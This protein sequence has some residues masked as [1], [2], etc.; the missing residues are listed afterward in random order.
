MSLSHSEQYQT[1]QN[2]SGFAPLEAT[3]VLE[4]SGADR[5]KFLNSYL[6]Q[7][8]LSM[9]NRSHALGVFLTQKG[10]IVSD[11]RV[12]VL[13][14]KVLLL[15]AKDNGAKVQKH[16]ETFLMF[17]QAQLE[18]RSADWRRFIF[19]GNMAQQF[20]RGSL[21]ASVPDTPAT[22]ASF[23]WQDQT[24]LIW[25]NERYGLE[26]YEL[27]VPSQ[28]ASR[29]RE[30]LLTIAP[31]ELSPELLEILRVEAGIPQIGVDM[32]EENLVAEVGLDKSAT[33]FNKGCYL[34]QE[35]TARVNTQGHVNRKLSQVRLGAAPPAPLPVELW[36]G[37][38]KAGTLTS[39][40]ESPK[41]GSWIGLAL[42]T[43]QALEQPTQIFLK[44]PD[45]NIEITLLS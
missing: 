16:L 26:C 4:L 42:L 21:G 20:L 38:K 45:Q 28:G 15:F 37:E 22:I 27:L 11:C 19:F 36:Q 25:A 31:T 24:L 33:S 6:T 17:S 9:S 41:F 3:E 1:L 5:K 12:L 18:D 23:L 10:K 35:T 13:P 7:D 34:G 2:G 40:A 44:A 29:F 14:D 43:R 32:G 30:W 8:L 39:A